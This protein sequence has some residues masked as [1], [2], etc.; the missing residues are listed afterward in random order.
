MNLTI[1]AIQGLLALV[2]AASGTL[3]ASWSVERLV[4]SG[5][6]GVEGLPVPLV[7]FI[8]LSELLGAAG[9]LLPRATGVA[10][11][12]TPLAAVGLGI[13]MV[14]AAIVHARRRE[15]RNVVVNVVIL[16]LCLVVGWATY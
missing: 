8:G 16:S 4:N 11:V 6:T 13:I 9:L 12:L 7:R 3:K 15:L 10:T 5:Q 2:F 1:W 14:L